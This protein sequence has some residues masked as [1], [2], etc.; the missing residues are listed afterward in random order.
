VCQRSL[1][2]QARELGWLV[3]DCVALAKVGRS[4][5][6]ELGIA[7]AFAPIIVAVYREIDALGQ[8]GCIVRRVK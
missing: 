7:P 8:R 4:L 6:E 5:F 1:S 2:G 3:L